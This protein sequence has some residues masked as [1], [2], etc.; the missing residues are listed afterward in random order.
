[1]IYF[2]KNK[3]AYA[4]E[5][6]EYIAAID[7]KTWNVYAGTDKWDIVD[8]EF[9]DITETEGY[10]A[11]QLATAKQAKIADINTAK[12]KAFKDGIIFK[13]AHFDCDDRAQDRTGNRLLLLQA[14]PVET[15][16]WLD[17]DYKPVEMTAEEFQQLCAAIFERVQ[18]IEF[19]TGMMLNEVERAQT[20]EELEDISINFEEINNDNSNIPV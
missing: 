1:M 9:V 12:E 4:Y 7:N 19:K 20:L 8:G 11:Q 17:Y 5:I 2:D 10:K 13:D 18:F 6:P 16:E 14:M 3:E 15:L